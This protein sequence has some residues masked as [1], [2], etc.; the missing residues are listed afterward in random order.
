M[1]KGFS[2]RIFTPRT[3]A[4]DL[5]F[6]IKNLGRIAASRREGRISKAF[7][8]KIMSV[9]SAVNGCV[10]CSWFHAKEASSA[11]VSASE[12][13]NLFQLQFHTDAGSDELPAL[14]YAQ[15]YAE[16]DRAPDPGATVAYTAHY[17]EKTAAEIFLYIRMIMFGNLLGNTY[18]AFQSRLKGHPVPGGN[19]FFELVF[20][21]LV[22]PMMF[23]ASLMI[24]RDSKRAAGLV[25]AP[26]KTGG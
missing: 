24:R 21:I 7:A 15:H 4:G 9:V 5:W 10:Y 3:L 2:K 19:P 13:A 18:D 25:Q 8:A 17:G 14:I 23:P 16:T 1:K 11:G 20:F 12:I 6:L 22:F 26:K